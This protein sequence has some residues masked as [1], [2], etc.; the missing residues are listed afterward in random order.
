VERFWR[1]CGCGGCGSGSGSGSAAADQVL[2]RG[3]AERSRLE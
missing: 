1:C 3:P 2:S